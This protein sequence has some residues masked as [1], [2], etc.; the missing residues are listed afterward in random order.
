MDKILIIGAGGF[1]GAVA[2]YLLCGL[3]QRLHGGTLPLGTLTVNVLGCFIIGVAMAMVEDGTFLGPNGRL[4]LMIG[5]LGSF[6]TF[7]AFGY[8]TVE[9]LRDGEWFWLFWSVA[10]NVLLGVA[11]VILGRLLA[12]AV[13]F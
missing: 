11:A 2:R 8:E 7:S 1:L 10:G 4:L 12:K 9:L 3:V 5:L 6:T 13:G